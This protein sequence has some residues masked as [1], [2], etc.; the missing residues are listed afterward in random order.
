MLFFD[1]IVNLFLC[2]IYEV[3]FIT[4]TDTHVYTLYVC[5]AVSTYT[6]MIWYGLRSF[7]YSK[8]Y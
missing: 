3:N 4:F 7:T 2:L 5:L 6:H 8:K 1:A